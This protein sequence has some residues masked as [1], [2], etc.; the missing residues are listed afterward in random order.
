ML[1][2]LRLPETCSEGGVEG[3][4]SWFKDLAEHPELPDQELC[5]KD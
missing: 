4:F 5:V 1:A 2:N 3:A